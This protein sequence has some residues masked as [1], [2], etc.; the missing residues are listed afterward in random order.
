MAIEQALADKERLR[1]IAR[2]GKAHVVAHHTMAAI[3]KY[4]V[5]TTLSGQS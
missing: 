5:E 3:A 4:V 2:E 1:T